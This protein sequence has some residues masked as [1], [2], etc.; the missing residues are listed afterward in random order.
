MSIA[1]RTLLRVRIV[2]PASTANIGS[3]FDCLGL[4]LDLSFELTFSGSSSGAT[5]A[6]VGAEPHELIRADIIG[7]RHPAMV[8]F[9]KSGGV[10]PLQASTKI[11]P[12]KGMG[13]SGAAHVAGAAA[14]FVQRFGQIDRNSVLASAA[15]LEGHADNAAPS[16]Y[17]GFTIAAGGRV[18]SLEVPTDLLLVAWIPATETSTASS[19]ARLP[20]VVSHADASFNVGRAALLVAAM[21]TGDLGALRIATEDRLH[22]AI[23]L[24][25]SPTSSA[26]LNVALESNA[27]AAWL[28]GSGPTVVAL[29]TRE[30]AESIASTLATNGHCK[31][32]EVDRQ[33]VRLLH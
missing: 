24:V 14:A 16:V 32:L 18:I 19:R 11:P 25:D 12:G 2:A 33:G 1:A 4:A 13:F 9:R 20:E 21:S 8:A 27:I 29:A 15:E 30:T 10:G 23:R 28:S 26:A 3:G 5:D 17:G 7:D 31:I 6:T 22:Q